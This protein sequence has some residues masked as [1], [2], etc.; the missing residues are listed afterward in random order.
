MKGKA[1]IIVAILV[2]GIAAGAYFLSPE[3]KELIDLYIIGKEKPAPPIIEEPEKWVYV[4]AD[5]TGSTYGTY[6][7]PK[8]TKEWLGEVA[9]NM[10]FTT[11]GKLY[12]SHIDRDSR[13]NQV[14]YISVPAQLSATTRPIRKEGEISFDYS[15]RVKE[16]EFSLEK[17]KAD[18]VLVAK[19]FANAKAE[20]LVEC[21]DLLSQKVYVKSSDNQWTDIIGIL[22]AS[23]VT[24][25]NEPDENAIKYV[26][27]FSDF[28]QDAPHLKNAKL[29]NIP[30]NVHLLAVNPVQN[31]SKKVTTNV[32]EYEHPQRVIELIFNSKTE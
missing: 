20:F 21:A 4:L 30:N 7:I 25:E 6:C 11:G 8:V 26:V 32:V 22:N 10:Y 2:A 3:A 16:W 19:E 15:K 23:F 14:I 18:S 31:S 13:N 9:D 24:M 27:G 12:L 1:I 28:I 17:S 5:G 29:D